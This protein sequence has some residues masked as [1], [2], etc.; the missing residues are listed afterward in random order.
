MSYQ[1]IDEI[2]KAFA[3]ELFNH[4]KDSKKAAGRALGTL[5][6]IIAYYLI[7]QWNLASYATIELKLPEF[8]NPAIAHNVEFGLHPRI[9]IQQCTI[10]NF[11]L[12]LTP[13]KIKRAFNSDSDLLRGFD[14][15]S[16]QLLNQLS[17]QYVLRNR[18][19]LG[20]HQ[21]LN[22]MAVADLVW[23]DEGNCLVETSILH[24]NPFAMLECKRVGVEEGNR[25]GPTTIEKAKQGAYVAKNVSSL[26][27]IRHTDGTMFGVLPKPDGSFQLQPYA[28]ALEAMIREATAEE[29]RGFV[30]T[31]GIASNHGNWFTSDQPNK[32]LLVL[33]QSYDWLLFL[34][35]KGLTE[36]IQDLILN[37]S[38]ETKAIRSAFISSYDSSIKT[39]KKNVFTKV[40]I[41]YDAH[42]ALDNYFASNLDKIQ[43]QWFNI[44][45]PSG[46]TI[47]LL[48]EQLRILAAK[49]W[50]L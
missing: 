31:V 40:N 35:D 44:I 11:K 42:L 24:S 19:W 25:K 3:Q 50:K 34:N 33:K 18:C 32:E 4:A 6:E 10:S 45:S 9:E 26:Q 43:N 47:D 17:N 49:D 37:T 2:Q 48:K 12:P 28:K 13:K 29:A 20:T 22:Q 21:Q 41:R 23:F 30:L 8:G 36:F 5:V 14:L 1:S 27:K 39:A 38:S 16:N 46:D 7:R 15:K